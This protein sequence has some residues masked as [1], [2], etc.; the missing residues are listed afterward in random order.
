MMNKVLIEVTSPAAGQTFDMF[1]PDTIQIGEMISLI[2]NVFAQTS[3]GTYSKTSSMVLSE[4]K[5]G[6]VFVLNK[7]I[8]DS[9]IRNGSKLLLF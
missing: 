6:Y 2:G 9:T 4:K 7:T 3:N 5:T 1:V 8:K